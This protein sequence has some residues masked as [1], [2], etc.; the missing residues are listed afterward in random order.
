MAHVHSG[1]WSNDITWEFHV[2]FELPS[3]DAISVVKGIVFIDE[4]I[5]LTQT[6]RGWEL[7][8]GHIEAGE[9]LEEG[10]QREMKEEAGVSYS[11]HVLFGHLKVTT[12]G[13]NSIN[14]ATGKLYPN[15]SYTPFYF[16]APD[17]ELVAC[18]GE[19]CLSSG[20]FDCAA[21]EVV[22]SND[23]EL[24]LIAQAMYKALF[25]FKNNIE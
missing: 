6:H 15:P 12:H 13:E 8:G 16:V 21:P 19:E 24:I 1:K 3:K 17:K 18:S 20:V 23:Y 9:T 7:P 2:D 10:L 11:D 5:V 25:L 22:E 14:K 4:K